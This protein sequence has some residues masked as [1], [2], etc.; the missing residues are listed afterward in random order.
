MLH[1]C[2]TTGSVGYWLDGTRYQVGVFIA[3][4]RWFADWHAKQASSSLFLVRC[5]TKDVGAGASQRGRY[6]G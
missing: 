3:R 1:G 4:D 5:S 6:V 2:V